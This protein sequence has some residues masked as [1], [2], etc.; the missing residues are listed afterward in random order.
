MAAAKWVK[1]FITLYSK[2]AFRRAKEVL[3]VLLINSWCLYQNQK[4]IISQTLYSPGPFGKNGRN[5][6][7]DW[8]LVRP[9]K[10]KNT[11]RE[12][13]EV[14]QKQWAWPNPNPNPMPHPLLKFISGI[15]LLVFFSFSGLTGALECIFY[16]WNW[17]G[18]KYC[19]WA[20]T[21]PTAVVSRVQRFELSHC[22]QWGWRIQHRSAPSTIC[23]GVCSLWEGHWAGQEAVGW[24]GGTLH[25][26]LVPLNY[27]SKY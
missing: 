23:T 10:E 7:G 13:P 9:L 17:L 26:V 18:F 27:C 6:T 11:K 4:S 24:E 15:S 1:L 19:T 21:F 3:N 16:F 25:I 8:A 22:P 2:N 14:K 20:G 5:I 12:I